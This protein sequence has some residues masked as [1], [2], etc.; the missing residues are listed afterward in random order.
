VARSRRP[1]LK[2]VICPRC[3][4]QVWVRDVITGA[5]NPIEDPLETRVL[6]VRPLRWTCVGCGYQAKPDGMISWRLGP[7]AHR[8]FV[9][10]AKRSH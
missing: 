4:G 1:H 6:T 7:A 9:A 5:S 2:T 8:E 10:A 3:A